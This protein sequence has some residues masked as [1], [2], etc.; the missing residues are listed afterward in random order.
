MQLQIKEIKQISTI[1][2]RKFRY[3][4]KIDDIVPI[5]NNSN[6]CVKIDLK[7]I[8]CDYELGQCLKEIQIMTG[9][10]FNVKLD[11]IFNKNTSPVINFIN[12]YQ[13]LTVNVNSNSIIEKRVIKRYDGDY[14]KN[15]YEYTGSLKA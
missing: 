4:N 8:I 2:F 10:D 1:D 14:R 5:N 15:I 7:Y 13:I 11:L 3:K 12:D 6:V 9:Y